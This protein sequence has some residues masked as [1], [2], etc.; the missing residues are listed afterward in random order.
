MIGLK[1]LFSPLLRSGC[2]CT[3]VGGLIVDTTT[4]GVITMKKV[5]FDAHKMVKK[6]TEVVFKTGT[7]KKVDFV[8]EK[9]VKVPVHVKFKTK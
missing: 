1:S 2:G 6:P 7:G 8:A 9:P 4:S 3:Y 5:E